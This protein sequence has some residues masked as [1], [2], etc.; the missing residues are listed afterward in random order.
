MSILSQRLQELRREHADR[1]Q[2]RRIGISLSEYRKIRLWMWWMSVDSIEEI[3][4]A[5][6]KVSVSLRKRQGKATV[7]R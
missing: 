4:G 7:A 1:T 3:R 5:D 2:A 6:G